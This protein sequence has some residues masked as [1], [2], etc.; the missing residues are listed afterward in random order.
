MTAELKSRKD[1]IEYLLKK[2]KTDS[3]RTES[4]V[5]LE[6]KFKIKP[7]KNKGELARS[8]WKWYTE[9][10][11]NI[12]RL[13]P[14]YLDKVDPNLQQPDQMLRSKWQVQT[15]EGIEWL[16]SYRTNHEL[17]V[18][19][20]HADYLIK[21]FSKAVQHVKPIK[22]K[23]HK[24]DNSK[25]LN[26]YS[27][28]KHI[29]AKVGKYSMYENT[30]NPEEVMSRF[31]TL[32]RSVVDEFELHGRFK[33]IALVDLG[34]PLDGFNK[35]TVRGGHTLP[36]NLNNREQFDTYVSVH[37]EFFEWLIGTGYANK[38]K[39]TCATCDNHSGAMG[40]MANRAIQIYLNA[41]YPDVDV[42]ISSKFMF[43]E[44]IGKHT[45]IYT[46]GKDEEDLRYGLPLHLDPKAEA[47]INDYIDY[48][49]LYSTHVHL[50]KG[51]LHQSSTEYGKRFRYKNVMS[52][53]GASKWI[54]TNFGPGEAGVDYE[55]IYL[56]KNKVV[57]S[58]LI[59]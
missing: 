42:N 21:S 41:K 20:Q 52:F 39:F 51:D 38:Y 3:P 4:W 19:E 18:I 2:L 32:K 37:I 26:I 29:G 9:K 56:Q 35:Q 49:K 8:Y 1:L 13:Y 24:G 43:H 6:I 47:K 48:H 7:G 27:S 40:Y 11:A 53:F 45:F 58:R 31:S 25:L 54:H 17:P 5:N 44:T 23:K 34:D 55:V 50:I 59:F 46:H 28:D 15:K 33:I 57:E 12:D 16:H 14:S 10:G 22:I 30:Y 36:Q